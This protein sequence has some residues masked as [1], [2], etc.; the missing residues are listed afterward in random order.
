MRL[1]LR[2]RSPL[3]PLPPI[4]GSRTSPTSMPCASCRATS[5]QRRLLLSSGASGPSSLVRFVLCLWFSAMISSGSSFASSRPSQRMQPLRGL[6]LVCQL[7]LNLQG[8]L[9][10]HRV[11]LQQPVTRAAATASA[12]PPPLSETIL[13]SEQRKQDS[14]VS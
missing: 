10:S 12:V 3:P 14:L 9:Q 6:G 1:A 7:F 4:G 2:S 8:Q 13:K 5:L 11:L